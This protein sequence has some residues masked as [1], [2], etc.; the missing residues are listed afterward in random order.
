MKIN[1]LLLAAIVCGGL[2]S[3]L[4]QGSKVEDAASRHGSLPLRGVVT[5]TVDQLRSD[6]L[7]AFSQWYTDGGFNRL[8]SEGTVYG[9]ASYPF[10]PVDRA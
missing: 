9:S 10:A 4:G 3:A 8:M 7:D 2:N 5:I 1:K 6:F